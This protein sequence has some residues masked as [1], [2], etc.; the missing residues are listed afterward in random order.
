VAGEKTPVHI[1]VNLVLA[2]KTSNFA[3]YFNALVAGTFGIKIT[4]VKTPSDKV[5]KL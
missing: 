3:A 1:K 5:K 4:S 2:A